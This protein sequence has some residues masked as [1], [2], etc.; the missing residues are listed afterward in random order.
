M[1]RSSYILA[2][3]ISIIALGSSDSFA[4]VTSSRFDIT[5]DDNWESKL[6]SLG[7]LQ[8]TV[9]EDVRGKIAA[10]QI[11]YGSTQSQPYVSVDVPYSIS[12]NACQ[13]ALTDDLLAQARQQPVRISIPESSQFAQ[14]FLNYS[15]N[16]VPETTDSDLAP[17]EPAQRDIVSTPATS[18][19]SGTTNSPMSNQAA[20]SLSLIH[21]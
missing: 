20:M 9:R 15:N 21:I 4:Q 14:V 11:E 5:L 10:I 16:K 3:A 6:K 7:T 13:I 17:S 12:G 2:I 18:S 19:G 1:N 8:S